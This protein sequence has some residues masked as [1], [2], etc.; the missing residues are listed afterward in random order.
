MSQKKKQ[1]KMYAVCFR[2]NKKCMTGDIVAFNKRKEAKKYIVDLH[3]KI[4]G[5]EEIIWDLDAYDK[6][7]AKGFLFN[8]AD[9]VKDT[10]VEEILEGVG[11]DEI[12]IG[13]IDKGYL[14]DTQKKKIGRN[15]EKARIREFIKTLT[16]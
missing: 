1:M 5:F 2:L 7:K 8:F 6:G 10:L 3:K 15:E 13:K 4:G 14:T 16:K 12:V 9:K 11:E